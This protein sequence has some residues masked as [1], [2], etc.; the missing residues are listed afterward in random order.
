MYFALAR[1][2]A[3]IDSE[4]VP[5][6][7]KRSDEG[8]PRAHAIREGIRC[9]GAGALAFAGVDSMLTLLVAR[10]RLD[11]RSVI[12]L[13][14]LELAL[15]VLA[16][17]LV[18]P[19]LGVLSGRP[20]AIA[21]MLART[22]FAF[23]AVAA[24]LGVAE[25]FHPALEPH[26]PWRHL[27]GGFAF[28][29]GVITRKWWVTPALPW[30]PWAAV[31]IALSGLGVHPAAKSLAVNASPPLRSLIAVVRAAN[32]FDRDGYGS[33]LGE[34]DCAPFDPH[35]HPLA[36]DLPDNG[37]DENCDGRDF[38]PTRTRRWAPLEL[39]VPDTIDKNDNVLFV[40][41]DS[42][43]YDHTSLGGHAARRG[44]DTTPNLAKLA[45]R[46]VSF[47]FAN[48]P[49]AGTMASVPSIL[50]SKF[51]HSGI[52]L[53]EKV[54]PGM[55]P[56]LEPSNVTLPEIMKRQGYVTG[57]VLGHVYF[58]DFGLAQG[59]D[60]YDNSLGKTY[61]PAAVT[62][63]E[64]TDRA[65]AWIQSHA[66]DKWFLWVHYLDPHAAYVAH[67]GHPS[68]GNGEEDR[69]DG[70]IAFTDHHLG[71]LLDMLAGSELGARTIVA[72]TADHGDG[73]G[74]HG[75][76]NH[77]QALYFELLHVPLVVHVPG[78]APRVAEGPVSP[79]DLVPT[80]AAVCRID[81]ADLH[82][83]GVSLVPQLFH[84]RDARERVVF[85]ET[86]WPRVLRA[87]IS[88]TTKLVYHLE[89]NVYEVFDLTADPREQRNLWPQ[90]KSQEVQTLRTDLDDWLERVY[91]DRD[92]RSNQVMQ[93]L[94]DVL[95]DE[96]PHPAVTTA[97]TTLDQGRAEVLGFDVAKA[98]GAIA[99]S[100]YVHAREKPVGEWGLELE[101]TREN[102]PPIRAPLL[103]T[104]LPPSRWRQGE[105]IKNRF[106]LRASGALTLF[107]RKRSAG[108]PD[109]VVRLGPVPP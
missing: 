38:R 32:D 39:P 89:D 85:A 23:G 98:D 19:A 79:I 8:A 76:T 69:Y 84:G 35:I 15:S 92:R 82:F 57:A 100:V 21:R 27:I 64:L 43:R 91:Y 40:T 33:L 22:T 77:G 81:V 36:A 97:G 4:E 58:E 45:E 10:E 3:L 94:A 106:E 75:F 14:C 6:Q 51:F 93:K 73:F 25:R 101:A 49:S 11:A 68:F 50:T 31:P 16:A 48:A 34:N 95:L 87:A 62:S 67:P 20:I 28:V 99:V 88:E 54:S 56:R 24:L 46:S 47:A 52:A 5:S 59:F 61:D 41:I 42:L 44:R 107:L 26:I 53:D 108:Q 109:E 96:P 86:N 66:D 55:P 71:R 65:I 7:S 30:L 102:T 74:E 60:S 72:V 104:L 9:A 78:I 90:V 18:A 105:T 103:T 80:L 17:L 13:L 12:G 37:V 70:E 2:R 83:E 63:A 1:G 29:A